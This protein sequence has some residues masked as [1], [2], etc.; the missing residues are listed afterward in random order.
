MARTK[1]RLS[2]VDVT[3]LAKKVETARAAETALDKSQLIHDGGGLYLAIDKRGPTASWLFRYM[4]DG[5]ARTMG[6]GPLSDVGLSD[7]RGKADEARRALKR[8]RV[9][10]LERRDTERTAKRLEAAKVMT[11]RQCAE[12]LH[13]LAPRRL[14]ECQARG[15]MGFYAGSLRLSADWGLAG[16]CDRSRAGHEGSGARSSRWP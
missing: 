6:L 11:F 7:A 4:I 3:R 2:P 9:D 13:R 15:A 10:P 5:K 12:S 1:E 14:E 16:R 8:D